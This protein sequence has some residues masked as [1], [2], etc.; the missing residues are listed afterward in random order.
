MFKIFLWLFLFTLPPLFCQDARINKMSGKLEVFDSQGKI[1]K[2]TSNAPL[3]EGYVLK[4]G[5]NGKC[6]II[7]KDKTVIFV[8]E[9]SEIK[10][11]KALMKDGKR[12]FSLDFLKGKILFFVQKMLSSDYKIKTPTAVC[13]VRG[14]DFSILVSSTSS[15]VGLFNGKMDIEKEN[16]IKELNPGSEAEISTEISINN[17]LSSLME[18]ERQRAAKLRKYVEKLRQK[19]EDREKKIKEKQEKN[20][21]KIE[22]FKNKNT[23]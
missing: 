4:T 3:Y 23:K 6:E 13:A 21:E 2:P 16:Q 20:R 1:L 18:K 17:R 12:D 8:S 7:F 22:K 15:L 9:N 14:T 10:I 5:K 19:M 11:D